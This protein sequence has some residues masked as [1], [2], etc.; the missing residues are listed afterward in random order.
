M[1][2]QIHHYETKNYNSFFLHTLPWKWPRF[3][4][5]LLFRTISRN[6]SRLQVMI[7]WQKYIVWF[8]LSLACVWKLTRQYLTW[9]FRKRQVCGSLFKKLDFRF[10]I[11]ST[12][13]IRKNN[14]IQKEMTFL[15]D[16]VEL[17]NCKMKAILIVAIAK[18]PIRQ[19]NENKE[20]LFPPI[21]Y[22][23]R[24]WGRYIYIYIS[25]SWMFSY[26]TILIG[27]FMLS[28]MEHVEPNI[29]NH[30]LRNWTI[31]STSSLVSRRF[32]LNSK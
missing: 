1:S 11:F 15:K 28:I 3:S 26:L 5:R 32:S 27:L 21:N 25:I 31:F 14:R 19:T 6:L 12:Y 16:I 20:Y 24:F 2:Y 8:Y 18:T 29:K 4:K 7:L 30:F 9:K 22:N 23:D 10:F 17:I 13:R